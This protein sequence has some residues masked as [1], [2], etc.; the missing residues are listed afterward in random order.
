MEKHKLKKLCE[1]LPKVHHAIVSKN[2]RTYQ[3]A[4]PILYKYKITAEVDHNLHEFSYL[5][6]GK[7]ANTNLDNC[8]QWVNA[9]WEQMDY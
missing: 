3:T 7:C 9:Y 6:E 8:K 1:K 5:P 2:K 4:Q